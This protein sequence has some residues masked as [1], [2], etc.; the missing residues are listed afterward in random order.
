MSN[1]IIEVGS[2]GTVK[3]QVPCAE[4]EQQVVQEQV[5]VKEVQEVPVEQKNDVKED[6]VDAASFDEGL[7]NEMQEKIN[8]LEDDNKRLLQAAVEDVARI[9]DYRKKIEDLTEDVKTRNNEVERVNSELSKSMDELNESH[10]TIVKLQNDIETIQ[11]NSIE[12]EAAHTEYEDELRGTIDELE[13]KLNNSSLDNSDFAQEFDD[14]EKENKELKAR[15][16]ALEGKVQATKAKDKAMGILKFGSEVELFD[17]E[18]REYVLEVLDDYIKKNE[19]SRRSRKVDVIKD[20]VTANG[21]KGVHEARRTELA[22]LINGADG[23]FKSVESQLGNLGLT[24]SGTSQHQ[25]WVYYGDG[26]Y[27]TSV[28]A[29]PS[30]SHSTNN[31]LRQMIKQMF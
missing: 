6:V 9:N 8:I 16:S 23:D 10:K 27:T 21:F 1:I 2:G 29:T 3:I 12:K 19:S 30:D 7:F 31:Q 22:K 11:A 14:L 17:D 20:I 25:K 15:L 18:I 5:V 24:C 4:P 13:E 26:R 28:S